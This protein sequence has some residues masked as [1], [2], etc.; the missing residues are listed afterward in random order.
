M[1]YTPGL[2]VSNVNLSKRTPG[3]DFLLLSTAFVLIL[4]AIYIF[5][6]SFVKIAV[7]FIPLKADILAGRIIESGFSEKYL[8]N[9][10]ALAV[11]EKLVEKLSNGSKLQNRKIH[12][13]LYD[14]SDF[15]ALA[16]P[17]DIIIIFRGLLE[18]V[19]SENELSFVLAHELGHHAARDPMCGLGRI[20][21][22]IAASMLL[23]G[24]DNLASS[25]ISNPFSGFE[26]QYSQKQETAADAFAVNHVS[27]LYGHTGGVCDFLKRVSKTTSLPVF[28]HYLSS[29]PHP[30]LRIERMNQQINKMNLSEDETSRLHPALLKFQDTSEVSGR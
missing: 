29:H 21:I 25:L 3:K 18:T 17:G 20:A 4:A 27:K 1:K 12:I 8:D 14:D 10:E 28:I 16:L 22:L 15:N 9:P 30:D 26:T 11:L 19:K 24:Q 13:R 23:S 6:A 7:P 5:L 2:P